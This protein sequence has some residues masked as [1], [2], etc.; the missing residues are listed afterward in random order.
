MLLVG[1]KAWDGL[2]TQQQQWLQAAA[3]ESAVVQRELWAT[4][5]QEAREIA[6]AEGVTVYEVDATN[7]ADK[8]E[9]MLGQVVDPK[10]KSTLAGI[11]EVQTDE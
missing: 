5:T 10:V 2:T 8:V 7:F 1:T 9:S 3:D 11:R 6:E 4:A